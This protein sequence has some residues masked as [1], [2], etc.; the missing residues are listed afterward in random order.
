M[1]IG[2]KL[3]GAFVITGVITAIVGLMGVGSMGK[4]ADLSA[5]SYADETLGIVYL[6]QA[7]V[8][9]IYMARA[10]KN[11]LLSSNTQEREKY[12]RAVAEF[13]GQVEGNLEKARPLIHTDGG[14]A[15]LTKFDSAWK[16]RKDVVEQILALAAKD[17]PEQSARR[18]NCHSARVARRPMRRRR[19]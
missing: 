6:K 16:E 11:M 14:R 2:T 7:N 19:R 12:R 15:G 18:W 1:K 9:L 4:I 3:I 5:S 13:S 8:D 17:R 10:E